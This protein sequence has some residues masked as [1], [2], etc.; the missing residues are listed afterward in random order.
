S[1]S[2]AIWNRHPI[3][4]ICQYGEHTALA[5]AATKDLCWTNEH[6]LKQGARRTMSRLLVLTVGCIIAT[7]CGKNEAQPPPTLSPADVQ[8][9]TVELHDGMD[10]VVKLG[11]TFVAEGV[12]RLDPAVDGL[13]LPI[14][15]KLHEQVDGRE[16]II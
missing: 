4:S 11:E 2:T 16:V 13:E 7:G 15:V 10:A 9:A 6:S 8:A 3:P 12:V 5:P 1:F 14:F